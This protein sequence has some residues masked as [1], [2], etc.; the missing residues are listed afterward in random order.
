[1]WTM[2]FFASCWGATAMAKKKTQHSSFDRLGTHQ[3]SCICL[4]A[5]YLDLIER[6]LSDLVGVSTQCGAISGQTRYER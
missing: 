2:A 5:E 3:T 4:K 1:M 6:N